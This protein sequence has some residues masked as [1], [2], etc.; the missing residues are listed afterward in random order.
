MRPPEQSGNFKAVELP[1]PQ[2]VACRCFGVIDLGTVDNT[3][4]GHEPT[5]AKKIIII[6][7]MPDLLTVFNEEKGEEPF[8]ISEEYKYSTHKESN[9]SKLISAWRNKPLSEA[10]KTTFDPSIMVGKIGLLSFNHKRKKAFVNQDID[11]ITNENTRIIM[12]GIG[13]LPKAMKE[14]MKPQMNDT[15]LWDWDKIKDRTDVFDKEKFSKIY[16]WIRAKIYTSD[17]FKACPTAINIDDNSQQPAA[18]NQAPAA[19]SQPAQADENLGE[20]GW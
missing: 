5:R 13:P 19:S 3:Y 8:I 17:D 7:E 18:E 12:T 4:P 11:K 9:L 6:W 16:K 15:I 14:G 2:T 1:E 20:D 10:E